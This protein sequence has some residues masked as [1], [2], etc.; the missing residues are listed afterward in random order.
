MTDSHSHRLGYPIEIV[1]LANPTRLAVG[2]TLE[3][4]VLFEGQPVAE[5]LVYASFEGFHGDEETDI[6]RE[7]VSTR[8]DENGKVKVELSQAGRWY[9]RLIHMV[10][11]DE[12]D[13]DYES[14]WATL[15]F[16]VAD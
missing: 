13:V 7:A 1:P 15:T 12:E 3:L 6:H 2:D 16:E 14:S 8:T 9:V 11:V 10:P 5:Q 4:L